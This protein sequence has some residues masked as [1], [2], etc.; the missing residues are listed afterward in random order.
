MMFL[1]SRNIE[2]YSKQRGENCDDAY[3]MV[4]DHEK[5]EGHID[6]EVDYD[7]WINDCDTWRILGDKCTLHGMYSIARDLYG[8]GLLRD[9]LSFLKSKMWFSFAKSCNRCGRTSDAQLAIKQALT[10]DAYNKQLLSTIKYWS[11]TSNNFEQ[12]IDSGLEQIL[13]SLPTEID[14]LNKAALRIQ[15][16]FKSYKTKRDVALGLGKKRLSGKKFSSRR[17]R[18]YLGM[19]IEEKYPIMVEVVADYIGCIKN[20][21]IHDI[22]TNNIFKLKLH[23][24]FMP[25]L[26]MG[27]PR[28]MK[29]LLLPKKND[30]DQVKPGE[31][32]FT[33]KFKDVTTGIA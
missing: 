20:L 13:K 23:R 24:P 17:M 22:S 26:Q 16:T 21:I 9:E 8:Q 29:A 3:R 7:K 14:S 32:I 5:L 11:Q 2:E 31:L 19:M 33:L 18:A 30:D 28:S 15:A 27:P 6:E 25:N 4:F 10:M 12:L 1:I